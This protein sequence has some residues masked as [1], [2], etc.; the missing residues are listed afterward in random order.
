MT[1][2]NLSYIGGK[3]TFVISANWSVER[4]VIITHEGTHAGGT[5]EDEETVPILSFGMASYKHGYAKKSSS[6]AS[7]KHRSC[8]MH[9]LSMIDGYEK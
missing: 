4:G 1:E 3:G 7:T 6:S 5:E 2:R 8:V 9:T